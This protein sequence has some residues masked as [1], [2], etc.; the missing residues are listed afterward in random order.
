MQTSGNISAKLSRSF[1]VWGAAAILIT[2]TAA[3]A[4]RGFP[5]LGG[6]SPAVVDS[7]DRLGGVVNAL[8][9]GNAEE[10]SRYFDSYVDLTL[11]DKR[12]GSYSKS[13]AKMVLRDFFDTYKVKGFNVQVKGETENPSYCIGTLQT[14]GGDFRT[15]LF[16]RQEGEQTL[17]KEINLAA[18]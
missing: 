12:V 15:T 9:S 10:L 5:A 7:P 8:Q 1:L 6:S 14:R 4:H 16:I 18:R 3:G 2:F 11:P 13:Q 17:I